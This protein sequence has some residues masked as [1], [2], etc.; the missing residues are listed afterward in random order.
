MAVLTL[1]GA[2]ERFVK[3]QTSLPATMQLK[4][5]TRTQGDSYGALIPGLPE[6]LAKVCLALVPRSYFPV[7]G[8]VSKRWMSFIGSK[9]FIAV[10]KEV[11]R[12]EELIYA[13][14]T[15]DGGKGPCW[16]VLGSLEQQNRMLPPMPGL[17]K[18]GFS[19]VV[20]D[21]KLLV[22][23]G[24]VVDYGKECVSDEVYQYDARLNR[25]AALAKMNV[26]RRDFACAEV[27][28][29]VYVAGG[30]GSDGDGLSSVEVYDP[31]RNKWTIIESLRRPRWGSFAC[32]FNGK[33]Y[34]MGGRSSFTIGN[35]RFIDVYDPILHSWTE[36]KKGCVMV[37]SHAVIDKR[38]FCIEWKNQRSLAIFNPSDSSWQKILVPLTGSSTTLFS[39]GV[40]DG[41]LLLFSQEEEPGYQTLM[42]D[43]TAPAGYEWHTSTLKPSGLCLC[44]VTIES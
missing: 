8:A 5:P 14:I 32:S 22:M 4:F 28:G 39:L 20:L 40:L 15:G 41:K 13:L 44:S 11:G 35:S 18:A 26:A 10:R 34:I 19:V 31:Q 17:T 43:P 23:A 37:T 2:R 6:D 30:F 21:G 38:L 3:A 27:N 12:L 9:E 25:W 29:A 7:M 33:L 16:E 24:Y 1:V 36:I 42:Y